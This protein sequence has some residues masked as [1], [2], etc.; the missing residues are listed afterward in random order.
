MIIS[1]MELYDNITSVI[2]IFSLFINEQKKW[3]NLID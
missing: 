3:A 1:L 2:V